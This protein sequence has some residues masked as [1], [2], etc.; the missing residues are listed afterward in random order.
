MFPDFEKKLEKKIKK[1]LGNNKNSLFIHVDDTM[2]AAWIGGSTFCYSLYL[3]KDFVSK[4]EYEEL[5]FNNC[6][7]RIDSI[8]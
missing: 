5:G 7:K 2:N 6:I 3:D 8:Q 1:K 4:S